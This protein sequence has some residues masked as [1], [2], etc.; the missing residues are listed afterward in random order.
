VKCKTT[1]SESAQKVVAKQHQV[2]SL[3]KSTCC[4][5][6]LTLMCND[7]MPTPMEKITEKQNR[8]KSASHFI[9]N[10]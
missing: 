4:P 2:R 8:N 7:C 10:S 9:M 5:Q 6:L 3:L 1:T